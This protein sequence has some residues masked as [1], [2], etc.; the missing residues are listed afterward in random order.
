LRLAGGTSIVTGDTRGR[1][2]RM[3]GASLDSGID[4]K[5]EPAT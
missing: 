2:V 1:A 4:T 5:R 3:R